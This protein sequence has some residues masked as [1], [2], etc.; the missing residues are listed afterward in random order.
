[1]TVYLFMDIMY[2]Y[3][4]VSSVLQAFKLMCNI[5]FRVLWDIVLQASVD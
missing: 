5:K 4:V 2:I 1:M 3:I